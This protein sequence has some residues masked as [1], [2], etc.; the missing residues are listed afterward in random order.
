MTFVFSK[1]ALTDT[2]VQCDVTDLLKFGETLTSIVPQAISPV[3]TP[4]L[5]LN[6][7][8]ATTDPVVVLNLFQGQVNLSYGFQ[9]L[10]TTSARV[11]TALVAVTVTQDVQVPYT[12]QNPEAITDLVDTIESGQA[13]IGTAVFSFPPGVDPSGGYVNWEFMDVQ[14]VVYSSGNA[15]DYQIQSNGLSNT[16]LARAVINIPSSTPAS[17]V[18]SK[19]QLRYTLTLNSDLTDQQQYFSAENVTVIGLTTVPLGVQDAVE[20]QGTTANMS[21]VIEK[22]YDTV[23]VEL[24][25]DNTLIGSTP[26]KDF[27]RV[28]S[29][30]YFAASFDT[31]MI[32][33]SL[34]AYTVIW[35]YSNSNEPNLVYTESANLWIITPTI[36]GAI[37]DVKAKINKA[38][39]T[40]YGQ[41]DMLFPP[42]TV[43]LWLRRGRDN[44]NSGPG[45]FTTFTML[46]AKGGVREYWLMYT[47]MLAIE[48]QYLAEG[49]KAFNFAGAA[50][51]LD[52]D[53]TGFLDNAAS[54][55][56]SRLDNEFK[57]FKQNL[58]IKGNTSGDGS[59]DLSKLRQGALG[60][61]GIT[62]TPA[63]PWGPYRSGLPYPTVNR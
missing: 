39:T 26:V 17:D 58:I 37:T 47:E 35:K 34:E 7:V 41:P 60:S 21:I 48:A 14:G 10:I 54:K 22:L 49:E 31:T 32:P 55:I 12:T 1:D 4:A 51:S 33:A 61:V 45:G 52:V 5:T 50:I 29:G 3:T 57:P 19:Y 43:L 30:Y 56:Q 8:S 15:F 44:F 16:V 11:L 42:E 9:L 46:N 23:A 18:N 36:M 59:A 2:M 13:A 53:R 40:L 38:R 6:Q 27:T 63:S 62:I 28:G 24:Y 25:Q 20:L